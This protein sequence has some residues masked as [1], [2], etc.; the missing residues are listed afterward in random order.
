MVIKQLGQNWTEQNIP[1]V[2]GIT[3]SLDMSDQ[4]KPGV[5]Y[6]FIR[7]EYGEQIRQAGGQPIF[8]DSSI[9]PQVAAQLCDGIVISGGE[10]ID[11]AL[12]GQQPDGANKYEPR[13]RTDWERQLISACDELGV[14]ILG[15]CYGSQLLNVHYGGTLHQNIARILGDNH[16]HEDT[17]GKSKMTDVTFTAQFLGFTQASTVMTAHRHHQAVANVAPG[18]QVAAKATDGTIEAING[19]GHYGIQWHAES[20]G[21]APLVYGPYVRHCQKLRDAQM[22]NAQIATISDTLV[23]SE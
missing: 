17:A 21:T 14:S 2:I 4:I 8:I 10:D 11:P 13:Q 1:P 16:E 9:E 5:T 12:Y 7:Q 15:I 23:L 18:F 3:M 20:D 6:S 22:G 19:R